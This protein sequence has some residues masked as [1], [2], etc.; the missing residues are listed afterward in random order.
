M[1]RDNGRG[2]TTAGV[3][4]AGDGKGHFGLIGLAERARLLGGT[5]NIESA[6][7]AGTR[8]TLIIPIA[9]LDKEP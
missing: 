5:L 7:G 9:P 4:P 8:M 3:Q 6:P 2:F 1:I